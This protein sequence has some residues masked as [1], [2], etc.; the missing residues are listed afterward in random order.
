[1]KNT[2]K[3]AFLA[4][5]IALGAMACDPPNNTGTHPGDSTSVDTS[6]VDSLNPDTAQV[7]TVGIV[8][9]DSI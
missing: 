4:M 1:M 7:D 3:L 5:T 8:K 6:V 9:K 2:L